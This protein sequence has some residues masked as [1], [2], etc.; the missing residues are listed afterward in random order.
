ME[1]S[2]VF[3]FKVCISQ[4]DKSVMLSLP[5]GN[6][7]RACRGT[8]GNLKLAPLWGARAVTAHVYV[9][10]KI[11]FL[12]KPLLSAHRM[13]LTPQTQGQSAQVA[14]SSTN[15]QTTYSLVFFS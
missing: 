15:T 6:W 12:L 3:L 10:G 2:T 9:D 14:S 13:S 7:P 11:A 8:P 5:P 1:V 4:L